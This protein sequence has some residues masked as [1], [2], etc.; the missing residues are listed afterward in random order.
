VQTVQSFEYYKEDYSDVES[1]IA[2]FG[3][4]VTG[5]EGGVRTNYAFFAKV[6]K[7]LHSKYDNVNG[8]FYRFPIP[9]QGLEGGNLNIAQN[10][11]Y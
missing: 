6:Y 8:K 2:T 5:D 3:P 11:G 4:E 7:H 10:P 1:I 9:I